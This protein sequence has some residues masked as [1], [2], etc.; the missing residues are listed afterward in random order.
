MASA[1]NGKNLE[2]EFLKFHAKN[3]RVLQ[4][5]L[6]YA[7]MAKA[8]GHKTFSLRNIFERI[9]WDVALETVGRAPFKMPNNHCPYYARY[10]MQHYPEFKGFFEIARL[11][12]AED[13]P[14]DR[15]GREIAEAEFG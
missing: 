12:S 5:V 1:Y 9:R 10:V 8:R 15:Y 13:F 11:R 4:E 7:R 3:P 6:R 2:E 14:V